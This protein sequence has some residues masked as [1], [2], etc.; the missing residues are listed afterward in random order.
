[1]LSQIQSLFLVAKMIG[2]ERGFCCQKQNVFHLPFTLRYFG[3]S[4]ANP[5]EVKWSERSLAADV[6]FGSTKILG[7][8]SKFHGYPSS[9]RDERT[10]MTG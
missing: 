4:S 1:M 8:H 3:L 9:G 2:N 10:Q 6:G 5:R 7:I